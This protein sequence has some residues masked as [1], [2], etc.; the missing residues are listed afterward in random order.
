MVKEWRAAG[1]GVCL[2]LTT[3]AS[4]YQNGLAERNIR[5]AETDIRAMLEET[6]LP[7]EF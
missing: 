3:I 1:S 6:G 4:L 7:L 2:E 5:T